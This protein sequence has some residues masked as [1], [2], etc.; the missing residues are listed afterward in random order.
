M[1]FPFFP[2]CYF[3]SLMLEQRGL[4]LYPIQ[5]RQS[6]NFF[7]LHIKT[8]RSTSIFFAFPNVLWVPFFVFFSFRYQQT[9]IIKWDS[10]V[11][12][13]VLFSFFFS[14]CWPNFIISSFNLFTFSFVETITYRKLLIYLSSN[15][16][17]CLGVHSIF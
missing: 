6:S 10:F 14:F 11:Q 2:F 17:H 12:K 9:F 13:N 7:S 1:T 4:N 8:I 15:T 16:Q 5:C 3:F